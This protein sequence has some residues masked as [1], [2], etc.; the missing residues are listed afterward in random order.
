VLAI[1]DVGDRFSRSN[2][3]ALEFTTTS[4]MP[5]PPSVNLRNLAAPTTPRA[6]ALTASKRR[7]AR[8]PAC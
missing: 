2:E 8:A 3:T 6:P 4:A 1:F 5:A 7:T